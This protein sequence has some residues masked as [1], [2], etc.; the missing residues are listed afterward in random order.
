MFILELIG[1]CIKLSDFECVFVLLVSWQNREHHFLLDRIFQEP[2]S[3]ATLK[4]YFAKSDKGKLFQ[5]LV[6]N[7]RQVVS[8][9]I[10]I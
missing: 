3:S 8:D 5:F 9:E 1:Y 10:I 6:K 4:K 2:P 7:V